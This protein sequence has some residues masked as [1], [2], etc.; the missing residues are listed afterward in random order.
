MTK[1]ARLCDDLR[2]LP[3]MPSSETISVDSLPARTALPSR[4]P[5]STHH[6]ST[7]SASNR[8]ARLTNRKGDSARRRTYDAGGLPEAD[9]RAMF[10]GNANRLYRL[11]L[12]L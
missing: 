12:A 3:Q 10:A 9:R 11:G 6:S 7:A 5:S 4:V 2:R 1:S 8:T